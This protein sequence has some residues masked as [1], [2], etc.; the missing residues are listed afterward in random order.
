MSI[1]ESPV[2]P[3]TLS[4]S[5]QFIQNPCAAQMA[6]N[7]YIKGNYMIRMFMIPLGIFML[8]F[9]RII[10]SES[11]IFFIEIPLQHLIEKYLLYIIEEDYSEDRIIS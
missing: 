1:Q 10:Q 11:H 5:Y 8:M 2:N 3:V 6:L 9:V 7:A 4:K